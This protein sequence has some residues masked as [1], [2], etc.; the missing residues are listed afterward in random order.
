L[1][2][3]NRGELHVIQNT[4]SFVIDVKGQVTERHYEGV[5]EVKTRLTT[6]EKLREDEMRRTLLG[7]NPQFADPEAADTARALAYLTV[8][9]VKAPSFWQELNGC[10][11]CEDD[12]LLVAVNN[13]AVEAVLAELEKVKKRGEEAKRDLRGKAP[14]ES[15]LIPGDPEDDK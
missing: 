11:E 4:V 8:R 10:L 14:T 6:R 3:G 5:F 9:L 13:A 1:V 15:P 7:G 12:N 2:T